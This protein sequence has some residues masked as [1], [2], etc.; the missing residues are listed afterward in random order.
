MNMSALFIKR[1]VATTLIMFA[2]FFF[3]AFGYTMLPVNDMPDI[4]LPFIVVFAQMPGAD[5]EIMANSVA[6]PLEQQFA[7]IAGVD[8]MTSTNR[9]GT[10]I[11]FL[12]FDMEVDINDAALDVQAAISIAHA[13]MPDAMPSPPLFFKL[14]PD[15]LPII[16]IALT[17][18]AMTLQELTQYA[19]TY[20]SQQ[21]SMIP[22]VAQTY[23]AGEKRFAIRVQIDPVRLTAQNISIDE[24]IN[25]VGVSNVVLPTGLLQGE[26]RIRNIQVDGQL[27]TAEE[28]ENIIVAWRD[29]AP[30]RLSDIATVV[31][32]VEDRDQRAW[33]NGQDGVVVQVVRQPGGNTVE[34][35]DR[36]LQVLPS[37]QA[38]LPPSIEM[39]IVQD[40]SIFIRDSVHEVVF[41]LWLTVGLVILVIFVFLR[42]IRAT[43]IPSLAVPFSIIATFAC[44]YLLGFSL[45]N[46]TLMGLILVVGLVVDDAIVMLENI[47]RH[48]EM[49][50][51]AFEA[52]M[53]GSKEIG[54][55]IVSM[56]VS[57]VSVFIPLLFLPGLVG[58]MFFE[59]A[60]VIMIALSLSGFISISLTPMMCNQFLKDTH[61]EKEN[62]LYR[63]LGAMLDAMTNFYVVTLKWAVRY[64]FMMFILSLTLI[65]GTGFI[66]GQLPSGFFPDMDGSSI[67]ITTVAEESISPQALA[68]AQQALHEVLLNDP[69]VK[70]FVSNVG[71]TDFS[72]TSNMGTIN[73]G[74]H[75]PDERG[76]IDD[77]IN[78]MRVSLNQTPDLQVYVMNGSSSTGGGGTAEF[79]YVLVGTDVDMLYEYAQ[80]AED[81]LHLV[82]E[83]RDVSSD[84]HLKNP[85]MEFAID[86]DLAT[87]LGISLAQIETTLYSAFG[88]REISVIYD[89]V[90]DYRVFIEVDR[91]LQRDNAVL[92]SIHFRSPV[93]GSIPFEAIS[94]S[95]QEAG[96]LSVN[97]YGQ[98][99]SV[100]ISFNTSEGET[101]GTVTPI[102]E[103]ILAD[104]LPSEI[105][106]QPSGS[107]ADFQESVTGMI[108]LIIV[109]IFL[110]YII[111]GILYESFAH[112]LTI[113]SGLPSAAF[114][115]MFSL[116]IFGQE[117][118][119]MGFI[120]ILM[121]VGIVKKNAIMMV[122][123]AI[124]AEKNQNLSPE[125]AIVQGC[126]VRFRPIM[127]TTLAAI[128]G[129]LPLA[130]GVGETG[131]DMR[132]PLGICVAGGLI[133]SQIVT[134][135][136][137]P[138][139]YVYIGRFGNFITSIITPSGRAKRREA[140]L[141][142]N[143]MSQ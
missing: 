127:M 60:A 104:T 131:S 66:A 11:V 10:T 140:K 21:L 88:Q 12:E 85:I 40:N 16:H 111:L 105:S 121:L 29:N 82:P 9:Q 103:Q 95:R 61:S 86:R 118:N 22:G 28:F 26:N 125:E 99:P 96:P 67:S 55:T 87:T 75:S 114:G 41:T 70:T 137:T 94:S 136:V 76:H 73:V 59:F 139:Y 107:A 133:F 81:A 101:I 31:D 37:I 110:I 20:I 44:M 53:D 39:E 46:V 92:S 2:L 35:V 143:E 58:L 51:T 132:M 17:S 65:W 18:N 98:F 63:A 8:T 141:K 102:V 25:A 45:N 122:D 32:D 71:G 84:L 116:W 62:I 49:G 97:H 50:K 130:L 124:E 47:I 134:L 113:L 14:N 36:I 138:A 78:R 4:E 74:L 57:L 128:M 126:I 7:T 112:P 93:G 56:T 135:Y 115:A 6:K 68:E 129:A 43:I 90:S 15:S 77:V 34:I 54:I 69:A 119:M 3:G 52:S 109:A 83:I 42:D 48:R 64:K 23:V 5:P 19:E 120:G 33:I 100:T 24:I 72:S 123:F 38:S 91:D 142:K 30:V 89:E 106:F 13:F 79:S 27:H 108:L 117:L 80:E 1:P